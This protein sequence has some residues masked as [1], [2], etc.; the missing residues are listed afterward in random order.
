MKKVLGNMNWK[1]LKTLAIILLGNIIYALTVKLFLLPANMVS[2]GTTG[3]ALVMN[4]LFGIPIS[5]FV[6]AFNVLMLLLGYYLIG[7]QFALTTIVSTFAYPAALEFF[8]RILGDFV[9]TQ[10]IF[11]C[12]VF[13]GL[14]VGLALGLVIRAGA[15]TG[16]MDIPPLILYRYFNIPVSFSLYFFDICILLLQMTYHTADIVLYGVIYIFIYSIVLDKTLL[17]GTDKTEIKIISEK[18]EEIKKA[19]LAQADRGVTVLYAEGGYFHKPRQVLLSIITPRELPFVQK[20]IC[21]IDPECF[22]VVS[23][24]SRVSGRG[25][26]LSKNYPRQDKKRKESEVR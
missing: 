24:V 16:G 21:E 9:L 25:F 5:L 10:D 6:L 8:H 2:G 15:S 19:I 22:M 18:T 17:V 26:T 13:S 23:K 20:L 14:G 4:H 1:T 7:K 3:I 11:L 12:A